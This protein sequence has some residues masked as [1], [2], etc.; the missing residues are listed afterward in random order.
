MIARGAIA[1]YL[2][3]VALGGFDLDPRHWPQYA[4]IGAVS[5]FVGW[6]VRRDA[7][8]RRQT[9]GHGPTPR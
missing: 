1:A 2:L 9:G 6:I 5:F 8:A 7:I 4:L 3:G